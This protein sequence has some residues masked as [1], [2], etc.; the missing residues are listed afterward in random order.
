MNLFIRLTALT[1]LYSTIICAQTPIQVRSIYTDLSGSKCKTLKEDSVTGSRI[2]K[3][4][5]IGGFYLLVADDD[6]RMSI[7]VVAPGGTEYPLEYWNVITKSFSSLGTK[8]EWRVV[9]RGNTYT[10]IGMIVRVNS[11][12]QSDLNAPKRKSYLAIT[13][14][15]REDICVTDKIDSTANANQ[16]ARRAADSSANKTCLQSLP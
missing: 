3:C 16:Q 11:T 8:A 6:S 5:G 14:I 7:S 15:T 2:Q 1:L 10:P 4:P 12:D 13:K 9:K